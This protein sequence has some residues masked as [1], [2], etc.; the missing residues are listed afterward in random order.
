MPVR[1]I[2][3]LVGFT[4]RNTSESSRRNHEALGGVSGIG[5]CKCVALAFRF[6][7]FYD[8]QQLEY[9]FVHKNSC[10]GPIIRPFPWSVVNFERQSGGGSFPASSN[11]VEGDKGPITEPNLQRYPGLLYTTLPTA[12]SNAGTRPLMT[13]SPVRPLPIPVLYFKKVMIAG[14]QRQT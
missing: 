6:N 14:S 5:L 8:T 11:Y 1:L 4:T 13:T 2:S 7:I 3:G 10:E 12:R 9:E